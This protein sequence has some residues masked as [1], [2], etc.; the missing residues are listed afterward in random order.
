[1]KGLEL[2]D[3]IAVEAMKALIQEPQWDGASYGIAVAVTEDRGIVL[4]DD[5]P[6]GF[7]VAAYAIADAMLA[8]RGGDA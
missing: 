3:H 6:R 7:A 4:S 1:M 8:A 2:R 5:P